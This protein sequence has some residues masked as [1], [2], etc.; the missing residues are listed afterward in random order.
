MIGSPW[1]RSTRPGCGRSGRRLGPSAWRVRSQSAIHRRVHVA[2][3]MATLQTLR[4][5][6]HQWSE[7][8]RHHRGR[9]L[10]QPLHARQGRRLHGGQLLLYRQVGNQKVGTA[11]R[12][13]SGPAGLRRVDNGQQVRQPLVQL[14]CSSADSSISHLP[15]KQGGRGAQTEFLN[16]TFMPRSLCSELRQRRH[17]CL[18]G[19]GC[20]R[21]Q[22]RT[23][24]KSSEANA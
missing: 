9:G 14:F 2:N 17:L 23:G 11:L 19:R 3:M 8:C 22:G 7:I 20:G 6:G 4:E 10:P 15:I 1:A 12:L 13:H 16:H 21:G 24:Y 5:K 18:H